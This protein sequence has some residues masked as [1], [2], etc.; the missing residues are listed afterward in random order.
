MSLIGNIEPFNPNQADIT[1]YIERIEQLFICNDVDEKKKVPLFLTLLGGDA[2]NV[3]KDLLS[4]QLP[5][6]KM[7][8]VL[9]ETLINHYNL[10]RLVIAERYKFYSAN[11]DSSEDIK[12]YRTKLKNLS[13]YCKFEGFL[14]EALRDKFVFGLCSEQIKQRLLMEDDLTFKKACEI[15]TKME[16]TENQILIMSR[17]DEEN[18]INQLGNDRSDEKLNEES[19]QNKSNEYLTQANQESNSKTRQMCKRYI[20]VNKDY[21]AMN[22]RCVS[23]NQMDHTSSKSTSRDRICNIENQEDKQN[24]EENNHII[25]LKF[26]DIDTIGEFE[27]SNLKVEMYIEK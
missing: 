11:Q 1:T 21:S 9:K 27:N 10:K 5:S 16:L 3:L 18:I 26:I 17:N 6:Q 22:S 25:E 12:S 19:S 20:K 15:A 2:Y 24:E 7:Y 14:D 8:T 23:C 4:P 13:K